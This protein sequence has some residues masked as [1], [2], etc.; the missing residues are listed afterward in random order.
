[1]WAPP[2]ETARRLTD[3][4]VRKLAIG[5]IVCGALLVILFLVYKVVL[6]GGAQ[7]S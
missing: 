7:V 4:W 3:P 5:A 1:M 2:T 6:S